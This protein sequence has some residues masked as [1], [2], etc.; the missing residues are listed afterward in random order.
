MAG[1]KAEDHCSPS[2]QLQS[3]PVHEYGS[4]F[5]IRSLFLARGEKGKKG[6]SHQALGHAGGVTATSNCVSV[7]QRADEAGTAAPQHSQSSVFTNSGSKETWHRITPAPHRSQLQKEVQ[8]CEVPPRERSVLSL[9]EPFSATP[10]ARARC[11]PQPSA[12]PPGTGPESH[13]AHPHTQ[14]LQNT[15][16]GKPPDRSRCSD[17][18]GGHSSPVRSGCRDSSQAKIC[19]HRARVPWQPNPHHRARCSAELSTGRTG[20]WVRV[21]IGTARAV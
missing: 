3:L 4:S 21:C 19:Q 5:H 16:G 1:S 14:A 7:S 2:S 18:L 15:L 20:P 8:Q 9:D 11:T 13:P 17:T 10:T 6:F 12:H